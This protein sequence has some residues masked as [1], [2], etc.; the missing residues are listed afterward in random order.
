M[1]CISILL[2]SEWMQK[3]TMQS[4]SQIHLSYKSKIIHLLDL[5]MFN[6]TNSS[7]LFELLGLRI[8]HSVN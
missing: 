8:R 6:L 3:H 7:Y 1:V 4:N 2:S 5:L